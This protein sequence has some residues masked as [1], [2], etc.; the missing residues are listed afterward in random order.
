MHV[1]VLLEE[2][3]DF[4][5]TKSNEN[6]IDC[7][8]G[9]GGH[10]RRL[11]EETRPSGKVLAFEWDKALYKLLKKEESE[12]FTV[13]NESYTEIKDV[14][15]EEEFSPV[16]GIL[17]DLGFSSFHVEESG[18]GFSFM[19]DE[20]L[21]MRYNEDVLLT[22]KDI[23]NHQKEKDII[24]ILKDYSGEKYAKKIASAIVKKRK[25]KE[26]RTTGD[27]VSIV[28]EAVPEKY[29]KERI[30]C[31][32]RTFQA[33]R[34]AVNAEIPGIKATLPLALDVLKEEGRIAI[35][36]FHGGEEKVVRD[37][38]GKRKGMVTL[39]GPIRPKQEEIN[40]NIRSRSAKL[41]GI[42]KKQ[43]G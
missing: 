28:E 31:A 32:T 9:G 7:T 5:K 18:R 27:L 19:R 30:H 37:F 34:V 8:A 39:R 43:D 4:L 10:A 25:E 41:Y 20:P 6:F 17:F 24:H 13:V 40:H 42:I 12:R 29:K 26:I 21:D 22:A 33:L 35:I 3:V 15:E 11:L 1:P 2:V 38:A 23:V 16:S 36:C 14:V